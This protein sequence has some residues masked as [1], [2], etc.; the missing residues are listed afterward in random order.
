MF[1]LTPIEEFD[2]WLFKRED[3]FKPL[4]DSDI[5]GSKC[6]LILHNLMLRA[7]EIAF[8]YDRK[9]SLKSKGF[10]S[11]SYHTNLA[12]ANKLDFK[13]VTD[14]SGFNMNQRNNDPNHF[15]YDSIIKQVE[16]IPKDLDCFVIACGSCQTLYGVLK[17]FKVYNNL[18]K[19]IVA[20]GNKPYNSICYEYIREYGVEFYNRTEHTYELV[21][22]PIQLDFKHEKRAWGFMKSCLDIPSGKN[23]FWVTGNYNFLRA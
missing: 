11:H 2:G 4:D 19:R 3:K 5:N 14:E 9:I 18:P 20:I 23:L 7:D 17:G 8:F 16:N 1:V 22:P 10:L 6:R 15:C 13:I 21:E 12:I